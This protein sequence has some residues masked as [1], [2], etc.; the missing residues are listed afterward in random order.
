[1]YT[2]FYQLIVLGI[3]GLFDHFIIVLF[4]GHLAGILVGLLYIKGP[5]KPLM[6]SIIPPSKCVCVLLMPLMDSIIPPRCVC[7]C[8]SKCLLLSK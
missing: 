4:V 6:D 8:T 5:L 3:W 2:L 1:L 7:A